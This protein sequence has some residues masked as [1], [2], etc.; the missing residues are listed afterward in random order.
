MTKHAV[1]Y[2]RASSAKQKDNWSRGDAETIGTELAKKYEFTTWELKQEI[3]SGE[4][5]A[6]RPVLNGILEEIENGQVQA[7]ICQSLSRL[8]R[9]ED[10]IDG[11]YIKQICRENNCLVITPDMPYDFSLETHDDMADF[12]FLAAKWQKRDMMKQVAQGLRERARSGEHM[13]GTPMLGYKI[14]YHPPQQDGEKPVGERVINQDEVPLVELIFDLYIE[15]G[16]NGTAKELNRLGHR[17]P[18]KAKK[19][20]EKTGEDDRQFYET[21]ITDMIKNPLYAG[22]STWAKNKR[23]KHLKDF[24]ETNVYRKELQ[25][26]SI[27]KWE[28]ANRERQRRKRDGLPR[29]K[30]A[31]HPFAKLVKCPACGG[32]MY[33]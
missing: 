18:R 27:E 10:G 19:Y 26:I 7:I 24:E 2:D 14:I 6:N 16:G 12:Q 31:N 25:I 33:R 3:K 15:R 4:E 22:F 17:K 9:D 20:R 30:W 23:S 29:A 21:D 5:L 13:G 32:C 1:I 11:R 28:L 8:S